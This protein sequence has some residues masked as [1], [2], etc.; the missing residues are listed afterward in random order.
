MLWGGVG[1]QKREVVSPGGG[2]CVPLP[3]QEQGEGIRVLGLRLGPA[4]RATWEEL[5]GPAL[6]RETIKR[7]GQGGKE[8]RRWGVQAYSLPFS[9][10]GSGNEGTML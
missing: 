5:R 1:A 8:A 7:G 6:T 3:C 10:L 2:G 9:T 4:L